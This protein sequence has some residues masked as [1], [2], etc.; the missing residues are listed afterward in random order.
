MT[1]NNLDT[2][3]TRT[4]LRSVLSFLL[5]SVLFLIVVIQM[6]QCSSAVLMYSNSQMYSYLFEDA[7]V[8]SFFLGKVILNC[9]EYL[10]AGKNILWVL[11][12][13]LS[14]VDVLYVTLFFM[15]MF[16][17]SSCEYV[18]MVKLFAGALFAMFMFVLLIY[19]WF[20]YQG[21]IQLTT[22]AG[23]AQL[24]TGAV[25]S[26]L[27]GYCMCLLC[28]LMNAVLIVYQRQ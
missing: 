11:F 15:L 14:V 26:Q 19:C 8:S 10:Y 7:R 2:A 21:S 28:V 20:L 22:D 3:L 24:R 1:L 17:D 23:F 5:Y 25:F 13:S 12:K 18:Y 16:Q 4:K 6:I 9:M 27:F